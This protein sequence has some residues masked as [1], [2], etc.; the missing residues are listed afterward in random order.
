M[1]T[2]REQVLKLVR[3]NRELIGQALAN[4]IDNALKYGSRGEGPG[5]G[6]NVAIVAEREARGS[7]GHLNPGDAAQVV[8]ELFEEASALSI[9]G[10]LC[11]WQCNTK[12][13]QTVIRES[14]IH[15]MTV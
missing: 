10:V 1:E 3:G 2:T 15:I 12:T 9:R 13:G 8:K 5:M 11:A 14:R 7:S 4:L 6:A